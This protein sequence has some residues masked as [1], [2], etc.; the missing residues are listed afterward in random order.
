MISL[1]EGKVRLMGEKV[2]EGRVARGSRKVV[3]RIEG[4]CSCEPGVVVVA[5]AGMLDESVCPLGALDVVAGLVT[6]RLRVILGLFVSSGD[7]ATVAAAVRS[8]W[9]FE[10]RRLVSWRGFDEV[11]ALVF[12]ER[13]LG[14]IEARFELAFGVATA[15]L[16]DGC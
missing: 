12:P 1:P 10:P 14:K 16:G 11:L 6:A 3:K 13:V 15:G 5:A 7:S 4:S 2:R 9:S 8:A